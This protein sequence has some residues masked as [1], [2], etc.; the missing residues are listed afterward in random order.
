MLLCL[1]ES[2]CSF[3]H[4]AEGV[5]DTA[6]EVK[7]ALVDAKSA[8][9]LAEKAITRAR[10]DIRETENRLAQVALSKSFPLLDEYRLGDIRH[11]T[12]TLHSSVAVV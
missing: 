1:T 12:C 4:R 7:Q 9:T 5:K 11:P 8:Q 3:R 6:E 10:A 2:L